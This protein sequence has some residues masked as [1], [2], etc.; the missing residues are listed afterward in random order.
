MNDDATG[1]ASAVKSGQ[2]RAELV[3]EES[4]A[5]IERLNPSL[6]AFVFVDRERALK[7]ARE[8]DAAVQAGEDPGPLAGVPLGVKDLEDVRG[9]PTTYGSLLYVDSG[10]S[11][12]DSVHVGRLV[13]AGAVP[14]GKTATP[15]FGADTATLSR[16][17]G[18][19]RNPWDPSR[20]PGGS[21]GGSAAAVAAGLVPIATGT[22]SGGSLRSPAAFCG[23]VSLKPT[24]GR[25]P[26]DRD[27][28]SQT[29]APGILAT[30]VRDVAR[31]LD[32]GSGPDPR[33]PQSLDR[34]SIGYEATLAAPPPADLKLAWSSNMGY[35]V[36]HPEVASIAQSAGELLHSKLPSATLTDS[37]FSPAMDPE[38]LWWREVALDA[39]MFLR[40]GDWPERAGDLTDT[41]RAFLE[42]TQSLSPKELAQSRNERGVLQRQVSELFEAVDVL[43][44]PT[45]ACPAF[46]AEFSVPTEMDGIT[47]PHGAEPFT[48]VANLCGCPA[49]SVP[50][51]LTGQGLPVGI[52]LI[53]RRLSESLLLQLAGTIEAAAPWPRTVHLDELE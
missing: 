40:P 37:S 24:T 51:G 33:D 28:P 52:Q 23:L 7:R 43:M 50:A 9:M 2:V 39:W 46:P 21:S 14:I 36:V 31:H 5:S 27:W 41:F 25:I 44:T 30:T 10:P 26:N 11:A 35:A 3:V 4:L 20:T 34:P 22:D 12:N 53:S 42:E 6:N 8:I 16:A 45:V 1:I 15:E 49:V 13:A 47:Y 18:V 17:W 32:L 38:T 29:I 48:S 19:T